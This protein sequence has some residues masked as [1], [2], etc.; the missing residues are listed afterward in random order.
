[1]ALVLVLG[2]GIGYWRIAQGPMTI[3]F[4]RG[5]I[6]NFINASLP[7]MRLRVK[8]VVIERD[9]NDNTIHLRLRRAQL[10]DDGGQ[11]IA[12]APRA[13]IGINA[14]ALLSGEIRPKALELIGPRILVKRSVDGELQLGFGRAEGTENQDQPSDPVAAPG[15]S[16]SEIETGT[17]G[18]LAY[19]LSAFAPRDGKGSAAMELETIS[20]SDAAVSI[21]DEA[22]DAIWYAPKTNLV[23][24]RV[25]YGMSL[26]AHGHVAS[27]QHPWR[28][29]LAADYIAETE[30]FKITAKVFDLV[31]AEISDEVFVLSDLAKVELPLD[32]QADLEFDR[33]GTL[34][35]ADASFVAGAGLLGFPRFI[36]ESLLVDEG[37]I[38]VSYVPENGDVVIKD[39]SLLVGG[40][41]ARLNARFSPVYSDAGGLAS[42]R[43]Q[44]ATENVSLDT[45]GSPSAKVAID[46]LSLRGLAALEEGRF[47]LDD[48]QLTA[49]DSQ[50]QLRGTFIEGPEVP[51][52]YLRGTLRN[53]QLPLLKKLWPPDAAQGARSWIVNHMSDA[54]TVDG[55]LRVNLTSQAL[56]AALEASPMP[57]DQLAFAFKL[58][59]VTTRYFRS[60]PPIRN[61]TAEGLLRGNDFEVKLKQGH[62]DLPSGG[63]LAVSNGRFYVK[64]LTKRG[65]IGDITIDVS[66]PSAAALRLIDH[67]P[68][69]YARA[70]G[71]APDDLGGT[72]ITRLHV[73]LPLLFGVT[74]E[75]VEI[76]AKVQLDKVRLDG[77]FNGAG[78]EGG[79]MAL[80]VDKTG[81]TG[82]G[83][84]LLNGTQTQLT[85]RE[86][87]KSGVGTQV[88]AT[89]VLDEAARKRLRLDMSNFLSG[90]VKANIKAVKQN[91]RFDRLHIEADLSKS[92]LHFEQMRW[93]R[94]AG[95]KATASFD[96]TYAADGSSEI[97]SLDL[98]GPQHLSIKGG[99]SIDPQGR[100]KHLKFPNVNLGPG[101]R[102]SIEGRR[103]AQNTMAFRV[104]ADS[105]DA[106]PMVDSTF[107]KNKSSPG[108]E[109]KP[110]KET[111]QV[112]AQIKTLFMHNHEHLTNVSMSLRSTASVASAMQMTG[113]FANG[114]VLEV[115]ISPNAAGQRR[116]RVAT[117]DGGSALRAINLYTRAH[118]GRFNLSA[119]LG[120]DGTGEIKNGRLD[121]NDFIVRNEPV[122]RELGSTTRQAAANG[123]DAE[124]LVRGTSDEARFD[125]LRFEFI[126]DKSHLRIVRE[127]L[128][129]GPAIGSTARGSIRRA[130][131]RLNIGGTLIP[132]YALNSA[133]SNV[134]ILGQVLM[135]GEGQGLIGV[136]F[137]VTG[138]LERPRVTINPVSALA[139]GFLRR[140]FEIDGWGAIP[141]PAGNTP[142]IKRGIPKLER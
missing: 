81:L 46:R 62:I 65:T 119:V 68:L 132:A 34:L 67:E 79:S 39:S 16:D 120:A 35:K 110:A 74:F 103:S 135:G 126:I 31:P 64:D 56:A 1:M 129:R 13:G 72:S 26:F 114:Q 106:R 70:A 87:F 105:F 58:S 51:A 89:V 82:K 11:L 7:G 134:P 8:D 24:K 85:W 123:I 32:G 71:I 50:V 3:G 140:L 121:Y 17:D 76:G 95:A 136:T 98:R 21:Y 117:R 2:A 125:G 141:E 130:D 86:I 83:T 49:G 18:F 90:T 92:I 94:A 111:V 139:P 78:I 30:R 91:G 116:L 59:N 96:V 52:V 14:A 122:L 84:V 9:A 37:A 77:V 27:G 104:I 57:N 4:L 25:P 42:V 53:I 48:L 100:L 33:K 118:S 60:L 61:A 138:S 115:T 19:M 142:G 88:D 75:Q 108:G 102:F 38:H 54:S 127:A 15:K 93:R 41:R 55:D 45:T 112:D 66:G 10:E 23:F 109:L 6:E 99:L 40:N 113:S 73:R 28:V 63:R 22:N 137:A 43:Y 44:I 131:G 133:L 12:R 20:I 101:N 5:P 107:N 97:T 124:G 128:I 69:K 80:D 29:E 47:D 36:T